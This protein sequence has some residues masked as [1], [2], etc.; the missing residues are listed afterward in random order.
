VSVRARTSVMPWWLFL[1]T[2]IA[3]LTTV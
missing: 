3:W 2:G 1:V